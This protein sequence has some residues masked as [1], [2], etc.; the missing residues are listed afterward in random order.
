MRAFLPL[1]VIG[2]LLAG[3]ATTGEQPAAAVA[4]E[5]APR[6]ETVTPEQLH[7]MLEAGSVVLIDVRTPY[8]YADGRIAGALNAPLTHFDPAAIPMEQGRETILYCGSSHRSGIAA[9]AL[10]EYTGGTV[11]HMAGGIKAWIAA[12]LPTVKNDPSDDPRNK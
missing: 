5:A 11:R 12:G 6:V 9:T 3:C 7:A 4:A 1:S 8:E 2:L 10:A